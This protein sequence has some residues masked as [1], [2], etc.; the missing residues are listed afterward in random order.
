MHFSRMIP[1]AVA[2]YVDGFLTRVHVDESILTSRNFDECILTSESYD[3]FNL[4]SDFSDT[5][6]S[7]SVRPDKTLEINI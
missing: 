5:E 2:R 6:S 1:H 7:K 4:T 3:E